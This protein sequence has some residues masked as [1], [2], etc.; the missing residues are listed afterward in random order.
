MS[1]PIV[2]WEELPLLLDMKDLQRVLRVSR[3][4]AYELTHV[5]GFPAMR[6]GRAIRISRESLRTFLDENGHVGQ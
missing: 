3:A 1:K 5:E 2:K 4:K 6:F